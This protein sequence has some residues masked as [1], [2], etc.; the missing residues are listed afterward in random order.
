MIAQLDE[1]RQALVSKTDKHLL[2]E[3]IQNAE[4]LSEQAYTADSWNVLQD[5]LDQA[6]IVMDD[7][8]AT[9]TQIDEA[10]DALQ[11]AIDQLQKVKDPIDT[12]AGQT[13][14]MYALLAASLLALS[15]SVLRKKQKETEA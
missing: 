15:V 9:Q 8:N 1:A 11:K 12:G 10:A 4:Q 2:A 3:L 5:A 14:A 7:D 13:K 6:K